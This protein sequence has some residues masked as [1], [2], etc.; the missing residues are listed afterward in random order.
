MTSPCSQNV[1]PET[2]AGRARDADK[3]LDSKTKDKWGV[4]SAKHERIGKKI[5]ETRQLCNCKKSEHEDK[6]T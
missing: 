1:G 4:L 3:Y 5:N 2:E 6:H